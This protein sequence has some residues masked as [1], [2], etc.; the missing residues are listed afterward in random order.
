M[1][2]ILGYSSDEM[3]GKSVFSF[4]S[5]RD[6]AY[7]EEK[8]SRIKKGNNEHFELVFLKKDKTP[9]YTWLSASPS[10]DEQG[11]FIYGLFVVSDVSALKKA[12]EARRES[13]LH[14]RTIIETSPNG[15]LV[16]DLDR[17][18]KTGKYPGSDD[19]RVCQQR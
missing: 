13:E 7:L 5:A 14:Y 9:A 3:L 15:I 17:Y 12:D 16:L 18:D 11:T 19:A 10:I 4:V 2:E 8:F 1:S 6:Q